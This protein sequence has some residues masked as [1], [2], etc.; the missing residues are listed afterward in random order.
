MD[1]DRLKKLYQRLLDEAYDNRLDITEFRALPTQSYDI[2]TNEW[3]PDS[4]SVFI[5]LR[6]KN[7]TSLRELRIT[8]LL[9]GM[10]GFECI[11]DFA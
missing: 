9:E 6:D 2:Q 10:F 8:N 7:P 5:V 3:V 1:Q 4:H 11:I